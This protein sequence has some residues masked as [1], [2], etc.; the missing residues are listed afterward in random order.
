M[1]EKERK[2]EREKKNR[3]LVFQEE[4]SFFLRDIFF[5]PLLKQL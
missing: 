4:F 3:R 5:E 2:E 1:G